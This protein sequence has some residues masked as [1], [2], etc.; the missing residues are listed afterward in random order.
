MTRRVFRW[1]LVAALLL[2][3]LTAAARYGPSTAPGRALI[4]NLLTGQRL[5]DL[6]WL[7]VEGLEGDPWTRFTIDRLEVA[8]R[9]GVWLSIRRLAVDWRSIELWR[10]RVH[11][12]RLSASTISLLRRPAPLPSQGSGAG[13]PGGSPVSARIDALDARIVL[14]PAFALRRGDYLVRAALDLKRNS[15][16]G[17]RLSAVSLGHPGDYLRLGFLFSGQVI[18]LEAHAREAMGGALAGSLGLDPDRPFLLDAAAHGS[19]RIGRFALVTTVGAAT[20]ARASGQWSPSG[21]TATGLIDLTASRWLAPWR[22]GVGPTAAFSLTASRTSPSLYRIAFDGRGA[23]LSATVRGDFEPRRQRTGPGGLTI[24]VTA[25]DVAALSGVGGLGSGVVAARLTGD[26]TAWRLAGSGSIDK[27]VVGGIGLTRVQGP[28]QLSSSRDGLSVRAQ[29]I[30]AADPRAG[31]VETLLGPAVRAAAEIDWRPGGRILWRQLTVHGA[32]IDVQGAGS[33]GLFGSMSFS[34]KAG[35]RGLATVAPGTEGAVAADWRATQAR[36][37]APWNISMHA[38]GDGLRLRSPE[39]NGLLGPA[40][41]LTADGRLGAD[42]LTIAQAALKGAGGDVDVSGLV[43]A[44]GDLK[45][46]LDWTSRGPLAV[47]PL[48]ITGATSGSGEVTGA[49]DRPQIDLAADIKALDL[50]D[51]P[52]LRLRAGRLTLS[53]LAVGPTVSG[54]FG[55]AAA[56]DNGPARAAAAFRAGPGAV[57]LSG[58]DIDAGGAVIRGAIDIGDGALSGADLTASLGPGAFIGQGRAE[59]RLRISPGADGPRATVSLTAA[60]V[61]LPDGGGGVDSLTLAADGPLKRLPYRI[62]AVGVGTGLRSRLQ[63]AGVFADSDGA[64]TVSFNGAGRLGAADFHT[65]APTE[66]RF[67]DAGLSVAAQV[68]IGEGRADIAL[69]QA[70]G[71]MDA[72][73]VVA[74][75]NLA[76]LDPDIRGRGDGVLALSTADRALT[77]SA[78]ARISGLVERDLDTAAPMAGTVAATLGAGAVNLRAEVSDAHGSKA[79]ADLRLPANLSASPFAIAIESRQPMSGR[80]SADG[81]IGPLW[82]L[83]EGGGRSLTG[84]LTADGAIS[85]T[86]ADPRLVGTASVSGGDFEDSAVGLKL[87]GL[88]L[89]AALRGD[90]IDVAQFTASDGAKGAVTGSGRL[91]LVRDGASGFKIGLRGF[92]LIDSALGQA[93]ASGTVNVD[94]AADGKVRLGGALTID[95]AQISPTPPIPSGV[96]PMD[97]IEIHRAADAGVLAKPPPAREPPVALDLTLGAPGGIFIKGRGLNLEMSLDARVSGSTTAPS[98]TGAARVV[99]GDYD[100]AGQRFQVDDTG[101]VR[102]GSTPETIRLDLTATRDNPSLTAV[103][104][105]GGT[106]AAPTLTLSST[107]ALP[108]DEVLSQ[109]LFGASASQLSGL[110]AAQL[111]SAVAGLAGTGGFDVI[112][113]LRGFAHLDRLAIDSGAAANFAVAG[114]KYIND[115]VYVELQGGGKTGEGGQVEWR[116]RKHLA[117]VSRVTSQGDHALSVR[118]RK[119]Y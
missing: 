38:K 5:G 2:G 85:G 49:I 7:K 35:V 90:A 47:G 45:V 101:T 89:R 41:E 72:K 84:R 76:V 19:P 17:G 118:W 44:H 112:G 113:G 81:E 110:Q 20:P 64:R 29:A 65:L 96:V 119:D 52:T 25:A 97:V 105:I 1:L 67:T 94:R 43:G 21:G 33:Q 71:R 78:Q 107:P 99:R 51:L 37:D 36:G 28:F 4:A 111:A 18:A 26:G 117:I 102:L 116:V 53:M 83:L 92:R 13:G 55:L 104:K 62:A 12:T 77:G 66:L 30:G 39:A 58:L 42:G 73:A 10:R 22:A 40:P 56:S 16:L 6:G 68:A 115:K 109:V 63:G 98:L 79:S 74:G 61:G 14:T 15:A 24:H 88:T 114:G 82:D 46:R 106:A 54:R 108:Q 8:D 91:S 34:G 32:A 57:S 75:L 59:G 11:I 60:G 23:K 95:H 103:I 80:F 50:P 93:T 70:R 87:K 100:F 3:L 48:S 9:G 31:V 69:T 27:V 86:L